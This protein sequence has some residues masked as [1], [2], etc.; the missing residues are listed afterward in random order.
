MSTTNY[1]LSNLKFIRHYYGES[2]DNIVK[3]LGIKQGT[4]S[5][6]ERGR[7]EIPIDVLQK[8][9]YHYRVT[10]DDLRHIDY[11]KNVELLELPTKEESINLGFEILPIFSDEIALNN[12]HFRK[13]FDILMF[14]KNKALDNG[15]IL[16]DQ[17]QRQ[18]MEQDI[19][20]C[21]D[22]FARAWNEDN[23]YMAAANIVRIYY[24]ACASMFSGMDILMDFLLSSKRTEIDLKEKYLRKPPTQKV[25]N[26]FRQ[27]RKEL[28]IETNEEVFNL[29]AELKRDIHYA[30]LGDYLFALR[31]LVGY[32]RNKWS[33]DT[34]SNIGYDLLVGL[35]KI[36]NEYAKNIVD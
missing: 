31:Y 13:A 30:D 7:R 34:N 23:I 25:I 6:Y 3:I 29:I 5:D 33:F 15:N 21:Y 12:A 18:R 24:L 26:C 17:K 22:L 14:W 8:I 19:E 10:V 28:F 2:Q 9:A 16:Q 36:G 35:A 32:Y 20:I 11:S 27:Q 4:Y 1:L